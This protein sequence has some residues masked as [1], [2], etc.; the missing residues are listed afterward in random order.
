MQKP[1]F[2]HAHTDILLSIYWYAWTDDQRNLVEVRYLIGLIECKPD[3]AQTQRIKFEV[4]W[5]LSFFFSKFY[6]LAFGHRSCQG[7]AIGYPGNHC[8]HHHFD[9]L[10][11]QLTI[12]RFG[13]KHESNR[14]SAGLVAVWADVE[15]FC[16]SQEGEHFCF[17]SVK[18]VGG[19]WQNSGP[20]IGCQ[21]KT[22]TFYHRKISIIT[23]YIKILKLTSF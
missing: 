6:L 10:F 16:A 22:L 3:S 13:E 19:F 7:Q 11:A 8:H 14:K 21:L 5:R 2:A 15:Y 4:Q 12:E 17:L 18:S 23:K 20:K 9:N 1:L